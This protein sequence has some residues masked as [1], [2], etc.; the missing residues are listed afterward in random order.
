MNGFSAG[1]DAV[2]AFGQLAAADDAV[3]ALGQLVAADDA[4]EALEQPVDLVAAGA[5]LERTVRL[6]EP[7]GELVPADDPDDPMGSGLLEEVTRV[8]SE[9]A[10]GLLRRRLAGQ[11]IRATVARV[12]PEGFRL[13]VFR[14]DLVNAKVVLSRHSQE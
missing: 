5:A 13:L 6:I 7:L 2:Q 9:T 11:G 12:D 14:D 1:H 4:I 8:P 10:A 3:Q